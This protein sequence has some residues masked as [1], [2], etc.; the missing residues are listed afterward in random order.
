M[1]FNSHVTLDKLV[2]DFGPS[3]PFCKT[4]LITY[5]SGLV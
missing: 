1:P 3:F 5:L 2:N 4:G